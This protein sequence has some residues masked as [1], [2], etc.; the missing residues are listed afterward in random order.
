M[1]FKGKIALDGTTGEIEPP[2]AI[3]GG[4]RAPEEMP[5]SEIIE[6][7]NTRFGGD[8][9]K[10]HQIRAIIDQLAADDAMQ[11]AAVANDAEGFRNVVAPRLQAEVLGHADDAQ[12]LVKQFLDNPEY[13]A[14]LLDVIGPLVQTKAKVARQEHCPIG[15]LLRRGEDKWLEYKST[16][17]VDSKTGE[18][19]VPVETA[20]IKTVAAFLNSFDGGTLLLGVAEDGEGKGAPFGLE[21][22]YVSVRK[23]GKG[24]ADMFD[25]ML[26]Q[27]LMNA[28][29]I[30]AVANLTTEVVTVD[31]KDI[32]RVH[33]K[34][35]GFP[36]E[37]SVTEVDKKGQHVKKTVFYARING[38]TIQL[39]EDD[40][41]KQKY[42]TQRWPTR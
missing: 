33:V 20:A 27:V 5:L 36:V 37:A 9:T 6:E 15:E 32:C 16:F 40:P 24:D 2:S 7:L 39:K 17:R 34:A 3:G 26:N 21:L 14:A 8:F 23:P 12:A 41:E 22:D 25:L 13:A 42:I 10:D 31:G 19:F 4:R 30:S 38:Q 11:A 28:L 35:C 18:K 1:T 29:G